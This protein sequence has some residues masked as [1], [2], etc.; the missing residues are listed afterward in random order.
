V[1]AKGGNWVALFVGARLLR[2]SPRI[3]IDRES[4]LPMRCATMPCFGGPDPKALYTTTARYQRPP[5][6][7][8]A[9]PLVECALSLRVDVPGLPVDFLH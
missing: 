9:E 7:L 2:L 3:G 4:A 5:A 1:D 8:L 6:E